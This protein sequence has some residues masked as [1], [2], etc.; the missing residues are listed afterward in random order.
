ML[1]RGRTAE[2]ERGENAKEV[3]KNRKENRTAMDTKEQARL[4]AAGWSHGDYADFLGMTPKEKSIVERR[5]RATIGGLAR[6]GVCRT[7]DGRMARA[8]AGGKTG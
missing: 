8:G 5:I 7:G 2:T 6:Q 4:E 1:R 3:R